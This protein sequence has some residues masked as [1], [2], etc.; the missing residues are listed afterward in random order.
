MQFAILIYTGTEP[1]DLATSGGLSM[2][3]RIEPGMQMF[4]LAEHAGQVTLANALPVVAEHGFDDC[5]PADVLIITGGPG[6]PEQ[7][8][9][10]KTLE[11][12][13]RF[14]GQEQNT[15]AS[16]CTGA[17]ILAASGLLAGKRATTKRHIVEPE[18]QPL[19]LLRTQYPDVRVEE[20]C[21]IDEG[22]IVTAGGVSLCIDATLY[23]LQRFYGEKVAAET[24]HILEYNV[25]WKANA[26]A[27][28]TIVVHG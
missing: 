13:R 11:F 18:V 1:I 25:A 5:P 14:A 4:T 15:V 28:Q 2:A 21:L 17:M 20:A 22:R 10:E 27:L 24:A 26:Q 9:N 19:M 23:L 12:I 16:V 3:R 6:W 7:A 8:K